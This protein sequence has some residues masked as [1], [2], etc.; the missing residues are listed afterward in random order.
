MRWSL[1]AHYGHFAQ[2]GN[3][4]YARSAADP[5]GVTDAALQW[6]YNLLSGMKSLRLMEAGRLG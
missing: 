3:G 5:P 2:F 6:A 4:E 1:S